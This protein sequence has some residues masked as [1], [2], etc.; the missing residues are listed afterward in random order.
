MRIGIGIG[1]G[2]GRLDDAHIQLEL[3]RSGLLA[4]CCP[5]AMCVLMPPP[6][7]LAIKYLVALL[8]G[9]DE[10]GES[11]DLVTMALRLGW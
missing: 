3:Q 4:L 9:A 7:V 2:T 6:L 1:I 8:I 11:K 10:R 5:F